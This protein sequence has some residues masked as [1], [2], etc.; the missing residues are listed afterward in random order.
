MTKITHSR[1]RIFDYARR[2][3]ENHSNF[4]L[5]CIFE[6]SI[7]NCVYYDPN[8]RGD[9]SKLCTDDFELVLTEGERT[10]LR[11]KLVAHL[12]DVFKALVLLIIARVRVA[13]K[14]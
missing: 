3:K 6:A 2:Y 7:F 9:L 13:C 14:K 10:L 8:Q 11:S 12:F 4:D 1:S 5:S